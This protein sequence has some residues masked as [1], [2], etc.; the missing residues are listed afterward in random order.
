[1]CTA[2][3]HPYVVYDLCLFLCILVGSA[4]ISAS[5]DGEPTWACSAKGGDDEE[6]G[7]GSG[8]GG[9]EEV[10]KESDATVDP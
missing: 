8:E 9:E 3:F 6:N 2:G 1:M 7:E 5:Q 10:P 4:H